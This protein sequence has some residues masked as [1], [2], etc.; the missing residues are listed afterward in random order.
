MSKSTATSEIAGSAEPGQG[1][2]NGILCFV[3][4]GWPASLQGRAAHALLELG[5][6]LGLRFT[7]VSEHD[8]RPSQS[9]VVT[10]RFDGPGDLPCAWGRPSAIV[11]LPERT[12]WA[13]RDDGGAP[14]VVAGVA[15]L[16][17]GAHERPLVAADYDK[18]GRI[19]SE[20]HPLAKAGLLTAPLVEAAAA[21][22]GEQ[23]RKTG[24][25]VE[26][27]SQPWPG[28][29]QRAIVLSHD[30]D[31]PRLQSPRTLLR[32]LGYGFV[33]GATD[34]RASFIHG[35]L[36]R[37]ARRPDPQWTFEQ[38]RRLEASYRLRSTFFVYPGGAGAGR[39]ARDPDYDPAEPA[40]ARELGALA[41]Q[42]WEIAVHTGLRVRSVAD[43]Q[44]GCAHLRNAVPAAAISGARPHYWGRDWQSPT[45]TWATL[46]AAGYAYDAGANPGSLGF[47]F[48][49]STPF[50]P[51]FVWRGDCE[52]LLVL[53]TAIMDSYAVKRTSPLP[54]P[55][56]EAALAAIEQAGAAEHGFLMLDWHERVLA[57]IGVWKGFMAP[58][59]ER[60]NRWR[61]DEEICF[62]TAGEAASHWRAHMKRCYI[63]LE[64]FP[65]VQP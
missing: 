12:L 17:S 18:L 37:L 39:D 1:N 11:R 65:A 58:L 59:L 4:S 47:R 41:E 29:A 31:G 22:L 44:A 55:D 64:R 34:G 28:S 52:G 35:A 51:S 49:T 3:L 36:T 10:Y 16:L 9:T 60:L 46:D 61:E 21:W 15:E 30:V 14:D 26:R 19:K 25:V 27:T 13:P 62:L 57:N 23:L 45:A 8:R 20:R 56:R 53:P 40:L 63:P 6:R 33:M 48:G 24:L 5:V 38:W 54:S 50:L 32:Y 7:I 42:G 2:R 43:Y